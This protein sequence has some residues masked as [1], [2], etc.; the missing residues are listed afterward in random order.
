MDNILHKEILTKAFFVA[1]ANSRFRD[2]N[3]PVALSAIKDAEAFLATLPAGTP[4]P[5]IHAGT[6]AAPD[7]IVS[8]NWLD[9]GTGRIKGVYV[10]C[11]GNGLYDASWDSQGASSGGSLSSITLNDLVKLDIA[12]KIK[13]MK[14][15]GPM[16]TPTIP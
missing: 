9:F 2:Q 4:K 16:P 7:E 3:D 15:Q 5:D 1:G 8:F 14:P 13:T 12:R 11:K 10:S 6:T